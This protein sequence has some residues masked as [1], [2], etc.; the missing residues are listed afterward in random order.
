MVLGSELGNTAISTLSLKSFAAGTLLLECFYVMQCRAPRKLQ[1][2]RFLPPTPIRILLD[3][4]NRDLSDIINHEQL[5]TLSSSIRKS[6]RLAVI[7]E[8]RTQLEQLLGRADEMV[9]SRL[10]AL[11]AE[12]D[13][14]VEKIVGGEQARLQELQQVNPAI[15]D[16]EI[17][18]FASQR[19]TVQKHIAS[20]TLELQAARVVIAT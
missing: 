15:R 13:T 4:Q 18:F 11:L 6:A 14:R 2:S 8:I 12:A 1:V 9:Q 20:A 7:K 19:D 16:D 3:S 17:A 10:P 5:N